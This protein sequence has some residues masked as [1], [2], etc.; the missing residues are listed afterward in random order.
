[1]PPEQRGRREPPAIPARQ[2]LLE[3][4][5]QRVQLE[6]SVQPVLPARQELLVPTVQSLARRAPLVQQEQ[7]E[8]P[9]PQARLETQDLLEL[10]DR[11]RSHSAFS[12]RRSPSHL[13]IRRSPRRGSVATRRA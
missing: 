13:L 2:A 9:V 11:P 3:M 8:I 5:V 7:L 6:M 1:M 4:S 12:S 10:L